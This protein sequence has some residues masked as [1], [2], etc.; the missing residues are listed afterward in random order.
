MN[1]AT[2]LISTFLACALLVASAWAETGSVRSLE[3]TQTPGAKPSSADHDDEIDIHDIQWSTRTENP[4]GTLSSGPQGRGADKQPAL[5]QKPQTSFPSQLK[6]GADAAAPTGGKGKGLGTSSTVPVENITLNFSKSQTSSVRVAH[7]YT[8]RN[9]LVF[10][11]GRGSIYALADGVYSNKNGDKVLLRGTTITANMASQ[12]EKS[13]QKSALRL[14]PRP[15]NTADGGSAVRTG[16][17]RVILPPGKP[18]TN[19]RY[20]SSKGAWMEFSNGTVVSV[21][22]NLD[23]HLPPPFLDVDGDGILSPADTP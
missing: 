4:G 15:V 20:T 22:G 12:S 5:R 8:Y 19:A 14:T 10:H 2:H 18:L 3:A 23:K 11:D 13:P 21:G 17:M 1:I 16:I 7:T 6:S 9:R